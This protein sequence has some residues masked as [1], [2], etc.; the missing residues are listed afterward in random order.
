MVPSLLP[1][2][3]RA[4]SGLKPFTF[5]TP[6]GYQLSF[7]EVLYAKAGGFFTR[8][9]LDVT[10]HLR[11]STSGGPYRIES[12]RA[13]G[14]IGTWT[15]AGKVGAIGVHISRWITSHGFAFNVSTDLRDF[16]ANHLKAWRVRQEPLHFGGVFVFVGLSARA[17]PTRSCDRPSA[18]A[19]RT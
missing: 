7:S 15:K 16:A 2:V 13:A 10:V 17:C 14:R 12:G 1:G 6:F 3:G 19:S 9:G 5:I 4:Q 8:E 11:P 18:T